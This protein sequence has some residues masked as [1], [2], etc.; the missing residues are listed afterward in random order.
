MKQY[1]VFQCPKCH[2]Y[3]Y[4]YVGQKGKKCPRCG[5]NHLMQKIRGETVLGVTAAMMKVKEK[6]NS[7][8]GNHKPTFKSSIPEIAFK[9]SF[10]KNSFES[11]EKCAI[12]D[13]ENCEI[14]G[15]L[16]DFI[17]RVYNFQNIERIDQKIGFPEYILDLISEDLDIAPYHR[18]KIIK[19]FKSLYNLIEFENGNLYLKL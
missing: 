9:N 18:K 17:G 7:I 13:K 19:K 15:D 10:E 2:E 8:I 11:K 12:I 3:T 4:A 1:I 6:Q 14:N 16:A 5:R